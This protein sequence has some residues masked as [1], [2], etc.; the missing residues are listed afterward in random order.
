M[1]LLHYNYE[2]RS[3]LMDNV[4]LFLYIEVQLPVFLYL[5]IVI[6][7]FSNCSVYIILVFE[8]LSCPIPMYVDLIPH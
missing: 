7:V 1:P 5:P 4:L 2:H 3:I 6:M 8:R